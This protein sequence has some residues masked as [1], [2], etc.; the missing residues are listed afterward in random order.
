MEGKV[1]DST[2]NNNGKLDPGESVYITSLLKN[3]GGIDFNNL[4]TTLS[5]TSPYITIIDSIGYFGNLLIDSIKENIDDPYWIEVD[6]SAPNGHIAQFQLIVFDGTF[7]DTFFFDLSV[8]F[9]D[10]LVWNPDRTPEPGQAI[11]SILSALGYEGMYST[12]L[13]LIDLNCFRCIFVCLGVPPNNYIIRA[14]SPEATALV[15][16]LNN[17]GRLYLEGGDVWYFDP[18]NN[19]GYNFC[20][21][22]GII[23]THDGTSDMGPIQGQVGTF[24]NQMYFN[25]AGENNF[26]DHISPQTAD[27]FL[28]F[29]DINPGYDCGVARDA[30]IYRTVGTSFEL[31]GLIDS[32]GVSTRAALL[33]SI[34]HFFGVVHR[35]DENNIQ[36]N[37][38]IVSLK[39]SPNPFRDFLEIEIPALVF[40]QNA[41][42]NLENE[43]SLKVYDI[44]GRTVRS[45]SYAF[46]KYSNRVIWDGK[47]AFYRNVPAGVYFVRFECG[48]QKYNRKVIKLR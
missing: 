40:T 43:G 36:K 48:S 29:R 14:A 44:I 46:P 15:N 37:R 13:P 17:G 35:I 10:Y 3:K 23:A 11:D 6:S 9:Y 26:M 20:P 42:H 12:T 2:G 7:I 16:Y 33:D 25:Y 1:Y 27:A 31:G 38:E 45:W 32:T 39:I 4:I 24:T 47:D 21:L 30:G 34:L 41:H 8:G 22:F 28:I 5:S 19:G 18:Y